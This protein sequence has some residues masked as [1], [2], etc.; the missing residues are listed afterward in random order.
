MKKV[1]VSEHD[2]R[3]LTVCVG[4]NKEK[5]KGPIVCW[6][7]FKCGEFAFKWYKGTFDQWQRDI[8]PTQFMNEHF[9]FMVVRS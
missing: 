1:I 2:A 4:C 8:A 6:S 7:C 5:E 9:N 3:E